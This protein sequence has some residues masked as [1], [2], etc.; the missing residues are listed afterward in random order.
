MFYRM[1]HVWKETDAAEYLYRTYFQEVGLASAQVVF[2]GLR[3]TCW[4]QATLLMAGHWYGVLGTA[5]GT[6]TGSQ[7]IE[8]RH[9]QWQT[10]V[11]E[12][13]LRGVNPPIVVVAA[14]GWLTRV[15]LADNHS[16]D[17]KG[18]LTPP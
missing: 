5:P 4:G 18:G 14:W 15:S 7:T 6:G 3:A 11:W 1:R 13:W 8:A 9:S 10:D 16:N 2:K 17:I 12:Q